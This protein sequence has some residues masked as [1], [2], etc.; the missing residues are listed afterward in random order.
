MN[1]RDLKP[2]V[3]KKLAVEGEAEFDEWFRR[4]GGKV[5]GKQEDVSPKDIWRY[6]YSRAMTNC[7]KHVDLG[8]FKD[9]V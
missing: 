8:N 5:F 9:E 7:L 4:T 6:A 2:K 1:L 3:L